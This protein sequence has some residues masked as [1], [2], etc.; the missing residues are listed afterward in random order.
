MTSSS[1][2]L[3]VA[4]YL[5][6]RMPLPQAVKWRLRER[7]GP[8]LLALQKADLDGDLLGNL[9]NALNPLV[10]R[11][12]FDREAAQ[13]AALRLYADI[14]AHCR[15]HGPM[16]HIIALPFLGKGGAERTA[17]QFARAVIAS[18]SPCSVGVWI[19][20][21]DMVSNELALPA[22]AFVVN[23]CRYLPGHASE[24]ARVAFLRDCLMT[25]RPDVFHVINSDIGWKLVC[26]EGKR[27]A[28]VMRLF[29][30]IFAF[31]FTQDFAARIGYAEYYLRDA[32]DSLDGLF[33][34][35][36][37]FQNDAI[38][39]YG[40]SRAREKFFPI[41]NACRIAE[42][43]W[44]DRARYRLAQLH[45]TSPGEPLDVLWAGR[46]DE[47]KRVDLLYEVAAQC[48]DIRFHVYGENV[49]GAKLQ[50]PD[51]KN[52]RY[53]GPFADPADLVQ[54][55][56]Y[57]AFLFY[58][59]LGGNAQHAARGRRLG[60]ADRGAG[61]WRRTGVDRRVHRIFGAGQ[62]HCGQLC[63]RSGR[64]FRRPPRC[65]AQGPVS[66]R[67]DR[68]SS[69]LAR[70]LGAP[71]QRATLS[72]CIVMTR[73]TTE[74]AA[75]M[76][77]PLVS[78]IVPCYNQGQYL[79]DALQSIEAAYRG[80]LE[81]IVVDDGSTEARTMRA[82]DELR[83]NRA[84]LHIVRQRNGG[85]SNARNTG[86][87]RASGAFVQFL[88]TDDLLVPGKI[89]RQV[90]HFSIVPRLD[91]SI[92][93]Y[94]LCDETRIACSK[95]QSAISTSSFELSDFLFHWERGLS[96]P[97]HCG[98]FRRQ[99]LDDVRFDE[100]LRAKED[101]V[102]W[103][104]LKLR[105]AKMAYFPVHGAVYRQHAESMR[106]S[107]LRMGD[108][109]LCA[110][111]KIRAAMPA[112][113]HPGFM[114]AAVSWHAECYRRHPTYAKELAASSQRGDERLPRRETPGDP[115]AAI[116]VTLP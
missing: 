113:L 91:V 65:C 42:G 108:S 85:L 27:L 17:L 59:S 35:N 69:Y 43:D 78:V 48:P 94:M 92:S 64:H 22:G 68:G 58:V 104:T 66:P 52:L 116:A 29:G 86:L 37:R 34:D 15:A 111:A 61:C 101:W 98:L 57:D 114:D 73:A 67:A 103:C 19:T 44:L 74:S 87:G 30:S 89:D 21:R 72:G 97:I 46:L 18:G 107:Y 75:T 38:E 53:H 39:T 63:E 25:L 54:Q 3:R 83:A 16:T 55:R 2:M 77:L 20:D 11:D 47:E 115:T 99:I 80:P 100:S 50:M 60:R 106:R 96:I 49:V 1:R 10:S 51:L 9:K 84:E 93:D 109:W 31:Q 7:V 95:V 90:D 88:D 79:E 6:H 71:R 105:Q 14:S 112:H 8:L 45:A 41:Y 81:V 28:Q 4:R 13:H 32:I 76:A 24:D 62:T 26:R 40:L 23:I 5:Y 33:S 110:A 82:L 70:V 36:A 102:F 56:T 12:A